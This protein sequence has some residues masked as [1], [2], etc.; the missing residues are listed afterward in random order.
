MHIN[1][2]E[3]CDSYKFVELDGGFTFFP[4]MQ[5]HIDHVPKGRKPE[6]AGMI[7]LSDDGKLLVNSTWS[8]TCEVGFSDAAMQRMANATGRKVRSEYGGVF[9]PQREG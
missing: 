8:S 7:F 1:D 9:L 5:N 6:S 2:C 4:F 3:P